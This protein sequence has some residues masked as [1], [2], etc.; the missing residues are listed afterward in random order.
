MTAKIERAERTGEPVDIHHRGFQ[1]RLIARNIT[2]FSGNRIGMIGQ[3]LD[4]TT[5]VGIEHEVASLIHAA[6]AGRSAAAAKEIKELISDSVQKVDNGYSL[7]ETA[8]KTMAEVVDAVKRVT[9]IMG[10]LT[11]AS[12]EQSQGIEQINTAVSQM[13]EVTQ[14]NTALVEKASASVVSLQRHARILTE[15][16]SVFQMDSRAHREPVAG[17]LWIST[18]SSAHT[19]AGSKSCVPHWLPCIPPPNLT[20][21][22]LPRIIFYALGRWIYGEGKACCGQLAEYEPFRKRHAE[23]HRTAAQVVTRIQAGD[24][25]GA[26]RILKHNFLW[27]PSRLL[28]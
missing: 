16:V 27:F 17:S 6:A 2:D 7:V 13:D 11:A 14:Q 12:E 8:G 18:P 10:E 25:D 15:G 23:F 3:W 22:R 21:L 4:R 26:S 1:L 28:K 9:D 5:E 24:K 19:K 20:P